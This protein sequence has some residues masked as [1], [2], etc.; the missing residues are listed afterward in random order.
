MRHVYC[1]SCGARWKEGTY[2]ALPASSIGEA[3]EW[4][5]VIR[6]TATTPRPEQ[7][8]AYIND[9]PHQLEPGH[10]DCDGCAT[11]IMPGD[12]AVCVTVWLAGRPT[13]PSWESDHLEGKEEG[14]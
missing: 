1:A 10:Y 11:P 6:G 4:A 5:R 3:A 14:S 8:I 9:V 7:R 12:Q 13:P 2:E